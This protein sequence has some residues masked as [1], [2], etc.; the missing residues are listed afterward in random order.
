MDA[1]GHQIGSHTWTHLNLDKITQLERHEQIYKNEMALNNIVGKIPTYMRPPYSACL[2]AC[3]KDMADLG[4][5]ISYFDVD[6]DDTNQ[7]DPS[8]IQVS[9]DRFKD[10]ITKDGAVPEKNQWLAI[11]HDI[12]D[13]TANNLTEYM[14]STLTKLGYKAV[15]MGECMNDP[16]ENWYR[17]FGDA[18]DRKGAASVNSGNNNNNNDNNNTTTSS[19]VSAASS[20][21]S[22]SSSLTVSTQSTNTTTTGTGSSTPTQTQSGAA[23]GSAAPTTT[24]SAANGFVPRA[25]AALSL[26]AVIAVAFA[27]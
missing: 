10:I 15:T 19:K 5:H 6:T 20:S 18:A 22:P 24:V 25:V 1:E 8:K 16:A 11:G 17:K 13:Q 2:N 12:L 4:Y 3:R 7:S 9:K 23:S 21:A 26:S 27:L 14:L